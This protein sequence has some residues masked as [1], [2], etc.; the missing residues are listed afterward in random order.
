MA[1]NS[2]ID[3]RVEEKEMET[4]PK[5]NSIFIEYDKFHLQAHCLVYA[6][7]HRWDMD[8]EIARKSSNVYL[9]STAW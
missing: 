1:E 5:C 2:T 6:C 3:S 7:L 8:R 9:K 4:C